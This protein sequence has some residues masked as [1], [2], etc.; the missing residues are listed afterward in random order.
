MSVG[1]SHLLPRVTAGEPAARVAPPPMPAVPAVTASATGA[2]MSGVASDQRPRGGSQ[3]SG[4]VAAGTRPRTDA[5]AAAPPPETVEALWINESPAMLSLSQEATQLRLAAVLAKGHVHTEAPPVEP[6]GQRTSDSPSAPAASQADS[7]AGATLSDDELA[8]VR[9]LAARDRQVR[10]HEEAHRASAGS[11]YRSGPTYEYV[12]GP[13]GRAYAVSGSVQIDTSAGRT[14]EETLR[15]AQLIQR[16]ALAPVDP[17]AADRAVASAAAAMEARARHEQV[18][19]RLA[20]QQSVGETP[21]GTID[22]TG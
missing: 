11:L 5:Q 10:A 21:G 4:G 16:S 9:R 3:G 20:T 19:E 14:P 18:T 7:E 2:A 8:V 13:D 1:S 12:T 15:K 17:S 6:T 22:V